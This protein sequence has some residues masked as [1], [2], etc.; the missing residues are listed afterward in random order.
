MINTLVD[1]QPKESSGSGG[2]SREEEVKDKLEKELLPQLPADFIE[3]DVE[4]KI[5]T[6][7]GPKGLSETGKNIPLNVCLSQEIQRF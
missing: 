4:E 3:A 6:M 7:R 1:T 2:K 5:R